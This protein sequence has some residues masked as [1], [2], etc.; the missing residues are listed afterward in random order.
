MKKEEEGKFKVPDSSLFRSGTVSTGKGW[1]S[2]DEN[3]SQLQDRA[4][5]E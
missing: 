4:V 1:H 3:Y 5:E 2:T